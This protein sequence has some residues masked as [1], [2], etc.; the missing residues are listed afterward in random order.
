L[1]IFLLWLTPEKTYCCVQLAD[2]GQ[3]DIGFFIE[4][5]SRWPTLRVMTT[6]IPGDRWGRDLANE[7]LGVLGIGVEKH[8]AALFAVRFVPAA[9]H[10]RKGVKSNVRMTKIVV[11]TKETI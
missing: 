2:E 10:V 1:T 11:Y 7:S 9:V 5:V 8:E 3:G 4:L 6:R